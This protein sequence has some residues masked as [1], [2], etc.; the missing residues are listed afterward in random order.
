M[1]LPADFSEQEHLQGVVRRWMNREIVTHFRGADQSD[2]DDDL[3]TSES[4]LAW[5]CKHKDTDSLIMTQLR[6]LLFERVRLQRIQVP[7]TGIPA[8]DAVERREYKP[9]I[10]LYFQEDLAD[11]ESGYTPVSGEISF[12]L[13]QYNYDQ[14]TPA[15]AQA[16]ATR[17]NSNFALGSGYIWRKGKVTVSYTD[18]S[19]GYQLCLYC[20]TE[21]EGIQLVNQVLD[22]NT[23]AYDADKCNVKE[24]KAPAA[25]FPTIPPLDYIYGDSR[26][27]PRKRPIA[28]V[29]F[30]YALLHVWGLRHPIPLVDRTSLWPSALVA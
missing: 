25:A 6:W 28:D 18:K 13:M 11:V 1:P 3:A 16:L 5:A 4:H 9:Q 22:I 8:G 12:R 23:D 2:L 27:L 21:A 7:I 24:N 17:I 10:F 20:R 29:R 30:Q 15:I 26:R 19:K 14:I